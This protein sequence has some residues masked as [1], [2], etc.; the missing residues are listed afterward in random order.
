MNAQDAV[1]FLSPPHPASSVLVQWRDAALGQGTGL[2]GEADVDISICLRCLF[3]SL[4][5]R[6]SAGSNPVTLGG[7]SAH[8]SL[9]ISQ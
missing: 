7:D 2:Q 1:S 9:T 3:I 4:S 6:H 5:G 8:L